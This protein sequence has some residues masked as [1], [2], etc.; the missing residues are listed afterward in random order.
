MLHVQDLRAL[1]CH[2]EDEMLV[3]LSF[4]DGDLPADLP[5]PGHILLSTHLDRDGEPVAERL[6]LRPDEGVII[7]LD[8]PG[9]GGG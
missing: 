1:A 3:L 6:H 9:S 7:R 2:G 4:S 5:R 8:K